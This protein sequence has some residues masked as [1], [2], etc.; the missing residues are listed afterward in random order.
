MEMIICWGGALV[1]VVEEHDRHKGWCG[2]FLLCLIGQDPLSLT[3]CTPSP[4]LSYANVWQNPRRKRAGAGV[5]RDKDSPTLPLSPFLTIS[6]L[7][8]AT[9][10]KRLDRLW[11]ERK[12]VLSGREKGGEGILALT[13]ATCKDQVQQL[14]FTICV[15]G[16]VLFWVALV[17]C[18]L[19]IVRAVLPPAL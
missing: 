11:H 4:L 18:V 2:L 17:V 5:A 1:W 9:S 14:W 12:W 16:G 7:F 8:P 6:L 15:C 10:L 3:F 13:C 19:V